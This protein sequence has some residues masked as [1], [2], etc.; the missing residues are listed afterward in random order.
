MPKL[1]AGPSPKSPHL[2]FPFFFQSAWDELTQVIRPLYRYFTK[3]CIGGEI[4]IDVGKTAQRIVIWVL[5]L[6]TGSILRRKATEMLDKLS[7]NLASIDSS[8]VAES[9]DRL[10]ENRLN[11][12]EVIE[13]WR[14]RPE[15][16]AR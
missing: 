7:P 1:R 11:C 15:L 4:A 5:R 12:P 6:T 16:E 3:G 10:I 2:K 9:W 14:L 8:L 13:A